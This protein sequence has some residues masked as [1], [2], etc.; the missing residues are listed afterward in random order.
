MRV[1]SLAHSGINTTIRFSLSY[2][3]VDQYKHGS[4][5]I[6]THWWLLG[7]TS[8]TST[9]QASLRRW[10]TDHADSTV[11]I[12]RLRVRFDNPSGL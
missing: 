10:N 7:A 4:C 12:P 8:E 1:D 5:V 11:N 3:L 6:N 2:L 9:G